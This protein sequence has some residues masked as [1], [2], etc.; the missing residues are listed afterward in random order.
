[1]PL[2]YLNSGETVMYFNFR[3][4]PMPKSIDLALVEF[5]ASNFLESD[6]NGKL[7]LGPISTYGLFFLLAFLQ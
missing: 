6:N 2:A 1:M 7:K 4:V 3:S 5:K